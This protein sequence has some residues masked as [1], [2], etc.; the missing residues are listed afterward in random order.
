MGWQDAPVVAQP[1]QAWMAAPVVKAPARNFDFIKGEAVPTGS[2]YAT[3]QKSPVAQA[4]PSSAN[5]VESEIGSMLSNGAAKF[6]QSFVNVARGAGQYLGMVSRQDVQDARERDAPLDATTAGKVGGFLGNVAVTLP[7]LAIPGANTVAG[8]G[9]IGAA[10]GALQPSVSTGETLRNTLVGGALGAGGQAVG[11]AVASKATQILASRDA[12]ATTAASANAERDS[13]LQAGRQAGYVVPPTEINHGATATALES[14]SGKAA[15]K[16]A[17]QAQNQTVTNKLVAQ[18]LGLPANTPITQQALGTVRQQAGQVYS[19]VK[20]AGQITSD[21]NFKADIAA[22]T[23]A[24]K[25]V[26]S[27]F[28]GAATPAGDQIEQLVKSLDQPTFSSA[29][30][31]EYTKRLRQQASANFTVAARSGSP[32]ARELAQAQIKGADALEEQIGRHLQANG[33]PDLLQQFQDARTLIA[34]S[35]QAQAALKGGNV[36]ATRLAQQL[37]KGKPMSDGFGLVARFADHFGD[38]T[39]LPKG[40]VGVSKLAATVGG[41]GALTAAFTGNLPLAGALAAGTAAPYAVR[42][43]L[44]SGVGQRALATPS[45]TPSLLGT[46]ALKALQQSPNAVLPGTAATLPLIQSGQ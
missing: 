7:A 12:A 4:D 37:Q 34:K 26:Q 16:Q 32:E 31:L 46:A 11:N 6:G 10:T 25:N 1:S 40:G 17:A 35:Y 36:S 29:Q 18:D 24:S 8:A 39:K 42:Q 28:P 22:I 43:S 15:T 41:G 9:L 20:Q 19:Q 23:N 3:S 30:A 5:P 44:L 27:G 45:Y 13:V 2:A 33:Q 38:A 14:I 21:A